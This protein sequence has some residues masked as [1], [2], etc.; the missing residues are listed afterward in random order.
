MCSNDREQTGTF[1]NPQF[2]SLY[3]QCR[4]SKTSFFSSHFHSFQSNLAFH[5]HEFVWKH[6]CT[7]KSLSVPHL[8]HQKKIYSHQLATLTPG[9][10][11]PKNRSVSRLRHIP[12]SSREACG[13]IVRRSESTSLAMGPWRPCRGEGGERNL[14]WK[15]TV[16][17]KASGIIRS[18]EKHC[19]YYDLSMSKMI[20]GISWKF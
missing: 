17:L 2:F 20:R 11:A 1:S 3:F 8:P 14:W 15:I 9:L 4:S 13:P 18:S 16:K 6:M 12:C 7:P 5:P 19:S 10:R